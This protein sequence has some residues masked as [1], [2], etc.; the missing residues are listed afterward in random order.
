MIFCRKIFL[1]EELFLQP[2]Y[3]NNEKE[4]QVSGQNGNRSIKVV[5]DPF[6]LSTKISPL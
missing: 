2:F 5:P 6:L 1:T 4:I 3:L